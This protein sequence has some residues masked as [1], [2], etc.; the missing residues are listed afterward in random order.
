[1]SNEGLEASEA[2]D[3]LQN[4]PAHSGGGGGAD[5]APP[6][7]PDEGPSTNHNNVQSFP[8]TDSNDDDVVDV[9]QK[10]T[11]VDGH[12]MW[13]SWNRVFSQPESACLDL[14]DNCFDAA[15]KPGF[16][17]K[18]V[19]K[20]ADSQ[21]HEASPASRHHVIIMNN[22][23]S[24]IKRLE[25]ALTVYK[26][27]KNYN[28]NNSQEQEYNHSKDAIGEN[29]VGLKHGCATL[30]DCSVVLTRNI[31][32]VE[33][34]IIAKS[35]QSSQGVYLPSLS[36]NVLAVEADVR[37]AIQKWLSE[38]ENIRKTL[39]K[40]FGPSVDVQDQLS[41]FALS[42]WKGSWQNEDHVFLLVLCSVKKN[43]ETPHELIDSV[44][45]AKAFLRDIKKMLPEY[46]I[47][48]PT[49]EG[50]FDFVIDEE[51]IDF[52]FWHRR[53]VE[54]TKF[55]VVV[56]TD[57]PFEALPE[58][59]WDQPA[60]G[61][62]NLS[63]YCGFDAQ[64]V[65]QDLRT[66]QGTSTCYLYIYSTAAGRLIKK[67]IDARH[68]LGLSAS[69]VDFTQGLTIL[70]NDVHGKLPLT[71]TKDGIAWSE[72]NN[73]EIHKKN[74]LAWVGAVAHFFWNYHK[75][76]F[77]GN[78]G[79]KIKETLKKTIRSFAVEDQQEQNATISANM[80]GA[81]FTRFEGIKWKRVKP[82]YDNRW[83]IRKLSQP[84]N[85]IVGQD[86]LYSITS[87][88]IRRVRDGQPAKSKSSD[89]TDGTGNP[90]KRKEA[91]NETDVNML[92]SQ[93]WP[94]IEQ[95]DIP[96]VTMGVL[97]YLRM[98]DKEDLFEEPVLEVL[99]TI[100]NN[101]LKVVKQPM[102][103]KTIEKERSPNYQSINELRED[104]ILTFQNCITF[105]GLSSPYGKVAQK[106]LH[107]LDDAYDSTDIK[108]ITMRV[109]TYLRK[110]DEREMF[111]APVLEQLPELKDDYLKVVSV[112]M[113]FRTIEES[114]MYSYTTLSD[115]KQ[116]LGLIFQNCIR[117]NG[118]SSE[119]GQIAQK[120]LVDLDDALEDLVLGRRRRK[121]KVQCDD[122]LNQH[123]HVD[124]LTKKKVAYKPSNGGKK[125]SSYSK[126]EKRLQD[127]KKQLSK[128]R[129]KVAALQKELK[130]R[131]KRIRELEGRTQNQPSPTIPDNPISGRPLRDQIA[132]SPPTDVIEGCRI[133]GKDD[134]HDNMLL[135]EGCDDEYHFYCVGLPSVPLSEWHC[136]FCSVLR[137]TRGPR[138]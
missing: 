88:R 49:Q 83:K 120:M 126:V 3:R 82:N 13:R 8:M 119:A 5:N 102:D 121:R 45:P 7:M 35:L 111:E 138:T 36:F 116:D 80:E 23:Q 134:D 58:E 70:V 9:P 55:E 76:R 115:L 75:N 137:G 14:L 92:L 66:K 67:E 60:N 6:Q 123:D 73:G 21:I 41:Q 94:E 46:Y 110:A 1:M 61:K 11:A 84:S 112:P 122:L 79:K 15:L 51:R 86:T 133:C 125:K 30:S 89:T 2:V 99:P 26:S 105:N 95:Q 117:F 68:M 19:M 129:A 97:S 24:P 32:T 113:D 132:L 12:G 114:R 29:G 81:Q 131:D 16:K 20:E 37:D 47:N 100:K 59:S 48:L 78:G 124:A 18:V 56:P 17:G 108:A 4:T 98:K 118:A 63:I 77:G 44:S 43:A 90:K 87:E 72:R 52:S 22:S 54:L 31:M 128:E 107:E 103:F 91:E 65:D 106:M 74:L 53:L 96:R 71:P 101:Y 57:E 93:P 28:S 69:G 10:S 39:H 127:T 62:Y 34:G 104:L 38:N 42:L 130:E 135:C 33:I 50:M 27:S 25:D 136:E 64:R 40:A 109:L 85:V